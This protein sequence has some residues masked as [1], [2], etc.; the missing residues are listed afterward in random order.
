MP[1]RR[2]G[3]PAAS[4]SPGSA[5]SRWGN[6]LTAIGAGASDTDTLDKTYQ[7]NEKLTWL[8]G[9]HTLKSGGQFLHYVQ[10]RFYAGNNGLLGLFGYGGAFTGRPVLRFPARSGDEQGTRQLGR[11][12]DAPAQPH[13]ALRPGRLQGDAGPD[14]QPRHAVGVH[15]A[16]RREGQPPGEFRP[17]NRPGDPRGGRR[18]RE[19]GALQGLQE[20]LRAA[21]R[22]RVA[23]RRSLGPA[24]RLRHL[25]VHGRHGRQPAAAAQPA[26]LLR[27]GGAVRRD[28]RRRDA[29][30]RLCRVGAA[31]PAVRP[32]A[33][34]GSEPAA[35]VHAAVERL[36]RVPAHPV[37]V[38]QRRIRRPQGEPPGDAGRRQPAAAGR[39]RS[40][41]PG[42]RYRA[43]GRC[44][45]R[46]R[47]SP[48]SPRP[49]RAAAATTTRCR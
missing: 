23:A 34:V 39:R 4:R 6:G 22:L 16:G 25:P 38:G 36:R 28:D 17:D 35:A 46:R 45:R 41:R 8:K 19:P 49:R 18:P 15:A 40:R 37:D 13:R 9:R 47:S 21:A 30:D 24:R 31:R 29:G 10:Q 11:A 7:I 26:V 27:I 33:G 43:A 5:R 14:A 48:T 12:V 3:S 42:R 32:G 2:S 44:S 1:T 20:G